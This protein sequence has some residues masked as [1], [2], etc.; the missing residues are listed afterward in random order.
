MQMKTSDD[1][2]T[3]AFLWRAAV[4]E[5]QNKAYDFVN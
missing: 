1:D 5:Q 3:E 4:P 2:N